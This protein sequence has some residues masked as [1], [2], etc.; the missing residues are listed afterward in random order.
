MILPDANLLIYAINRDCREHQVASQWLDTIL[1]SNEGI[2]LAW[3]VILAFLR[4]TTKKT[5]FDRPL[6]IDTSWSIVQGWLNHP[7]VSIAH[8]GPEH[9]RILQ[10]LLRSSSATGDLITDAHLA[11]LAIEHDAEIQSEDGDFA[12]FQ[13]LRWKNPLQPL[14]P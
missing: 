2:L 1:A 4:I 13:G 10:R 12:R 7:L 3:V 11:A 8:P 14:L 6:T 9:P 5:I